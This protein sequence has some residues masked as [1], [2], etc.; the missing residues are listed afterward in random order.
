MKYIIIRAKTESTK[1]A[2]LR[3]GEIKNKLKRDCGGA[4]LCSLDVVG[5]RL[6]ILGST[7][8]LGNWGELIN[9][10]LKESKGEIELILSDGLPVYQNGL[11]KDYPRTIIT[12]W[13]STEDDLVNPLCNP[14]CIYPGSEFTNAMFASLDDLDNL[15]FEYWGMPDLGCNI[16]FFPFSLDRKYVVLEVMKDQDYPGI[17]EHK[18]ARSVVSQIEMYI[19]DSLYTFNHLR[20]LI[21]RCSGDMRKKVKEIDLELKLNLSTIVEENIGMLL[22]GTNKLE[23]GGDT[24]PGPGSVRVYCPD[25]L[26]E[27][28]EDWHHTIKKHG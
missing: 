25:Y 28:F 21:K 14:N 26:K 23:F 20:N 13:T 16:G 3:L 7:V 6:I 19:F 8:K 27:E 24:R 4:R 17:L 10:I 1:Q 9:G 2:I 11:E 18:T 22:V 5:K 12:E 15:Y